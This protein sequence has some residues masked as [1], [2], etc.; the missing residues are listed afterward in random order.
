M[1]KIKK[2]KVNHQKRNKDESLAHQILSEDAPKASVRV[3][4]RKR[5][6]DSEK[7]PFFCTVTNSWPDLNTILRTY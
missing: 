7:V 5:V 3:K 2:L 1:G 4:E 6:D